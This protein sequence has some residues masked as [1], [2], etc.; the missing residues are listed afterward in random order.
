MLFT[1]DTISFAQKRESASK[2]KE[3]DSED[4]TRGP[5]QKTAIP[6]AETSEA[7]RETLF[8]RVSKLCMSLLPNLLV[9]DASLILQATQATSPVHL[10]L[11]IIVE[12]RR[13]LGVSSELI[14]DCRVSD[15]ALLFM[16]FG[17]ALLP[18]KRF[19]ASNEKRPSE[20]EICEQS[21]MEKMLQEMETVYQMVQKLQSSLYNKTFPSTSCSA[22]AL[23]RDQ[24]HSTKAEE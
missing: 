11:A 17:D 12:A 14:N 7:Q 9:Y 2:D 20:P 22:R 19:R 23:N 4:R 1:T 18:K 5:P 21:A 16:A 24:S 6:M 15:A 13:S 10:A 8:S 3:D